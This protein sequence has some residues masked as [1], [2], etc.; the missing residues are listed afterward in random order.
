MIDEGVRVKII[1][2]IYV[3]VV[4]TADISLIT[5]KQSTVTTNE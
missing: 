4:S 2:I 1:M 3:V 5:R